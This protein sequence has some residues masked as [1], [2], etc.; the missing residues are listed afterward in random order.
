MGKLLA[1]M[2]G[3][4]E[5]FTNGCKV[6]GVGYVAVSPLLRGLLSRTQFDLSNL[7]KAKFESIFWCSKE[8]PLFVYSTQSQWC[9]YL[10]YSTSVRIASCTSLHVL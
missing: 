6:D 5:M 2:S 8:V 4:S 7:T 3:V 10:Y 9:R 1:V